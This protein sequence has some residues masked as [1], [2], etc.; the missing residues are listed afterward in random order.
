M[1]DESPSP[2]EDHIR[3]TELDTKR[4]RALGIYY[5]PRSAAALL[6]KW[7]IRSAADQVLEPSFGGCTILEAAVNQLR[8][9]GCNEPSTQLFG[10]DVDESAFGH[11]RRVLGISQHAHF[12]LQDFLTVNPNQTTVDAVIA[13]PP[14]VSYHRMDDMQRETIRNWRARYMPPFAM[15]ASLWAYFLAHS[16]SF[17]KPGGRMAFVLPFAAY[18]SDY[19]QPILD[20]LQTEFETLSVYRM[21]EQ[22]FIQ[23]GAEERT[24]I[25]LAEGHRAQSGRSRQRIE[26]P[27]ENIQ[28]LREILQKCTSVSP[29]IE[30]VSSVALP[31]ALAMSLI[32]AAMGREAVRHLGDVVT[33]K[34]GEVVG[35]TRYLVK[36]GDEWD[37]L[38]VPRRCLRPLLTRVKQSPG[39]QLTP[40]EISDLYGAVPFLL[41][42]HESKHAVIREYLE[43]YPATLR[44]KNRTFAKRSPWYS[45][46]Y[47]TTAAAFIG[48]MAHESPRMIWNSAKIS[49]AN[50]LYKL[51]RRKGSRWGILLAAASSTTLFRLSAEL[52]A[53]VRG[54]GVLK[55]EPGDVAKLIIPGAPLKL[56]SSVTRQ[57]VR[58]IDSMVRSK[59]YESA[60]RLADKV[61]YLDTGIFT[62]AEI[63]VLRDQLHD[64]K[65]QRLPTTR[66]S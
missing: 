22:L 39:I 31:N 65:R 56:E 29:S 57:I 66:F 32:Q 4:R 19:S 9:L 61:F 7:A 17:L 63:N 37:L 28:E 33:V 53:R 48:S 13:N 11:L 15:T 47:D 27:V 1:L 14:F 54:A 49:C 10:F 58:Q 40:R 64:L 20:M 16:I 2:F 12:T 25:L 51:H 30:E 36:S 38:K 5:T 46:G 42:P 43:A 62:T 3:P 34:I 50:G 52:Q 59:E 26:R 44:L 24:V 35:D 60:T 41:Y 55:L 6:A 21:R 23:A 18:S 45:V 8:A